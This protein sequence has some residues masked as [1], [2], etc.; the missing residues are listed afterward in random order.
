MPHTIDALLPRWDVRGVHRIDIASTPLVIHSHVR[1]LDLGSSPL[2]RV[3]FTLRGMPRESLTMDGLLRL[4][5]R[6]VEE[7]PGRELVLGIIGRFWRLR[8]RPVRFEPADFAAW[9][10]PAHAKAAWS[11]VM[12]PAPD[13]SGMTR[14]VT[15]TRVHCTDDA[16]RA[17]FLR[18]WRVIRPFSGMIRLVALRQIRRQAEAGAGAQPNAD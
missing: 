6:L 4:G 13:A 9:S 1:T 8:E 14:L 3:L 17:A 7:R 16:S 18:Y 12:E 2:A 5:F 15:E 11:F 10:Q